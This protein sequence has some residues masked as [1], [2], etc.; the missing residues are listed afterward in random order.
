MTSLKK[1]RQFDENS[2]LDVRYMIL[3]DIISRICVFFS[4]LFE[5]T[6]VSCRVVDE[7]PTLDTVYVTAVNQKDWEMLVNIAH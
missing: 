3:F 7:L 6:I 4:G 5:G 2:A 1:R